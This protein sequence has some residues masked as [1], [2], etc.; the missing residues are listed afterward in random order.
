MTVLKRTLITLTSLTTLAYAGGSCD[1]SQ[2]GD[3]KVNWT[4]YKTPLKIGV[5]GSFNKVDYVAAAP[6]GKNFREI[7]V[8]S[9][10]TI[11][12]ASV[13]SNNE[14]RDATLLNAFFKKMVGEAIHAK[15]VDI[16]AQKVKRGE[17]KVG[18]VTLQVR[19]NDIAKRVPMRY[20]FKDGLL[21]ANGNIDLADFNAL[22]A[23]GTLNK[24]CFDL[25][26]GKTWSDVT[27]GF[28]MKISALLCHP[29]EIKQ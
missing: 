3:V 14:G 19:M 20:R 11:D 7:L 17:P 25:H 22:G 5:N 8:G 27:I 26:D 28:E 15:I 6:V 16:K 21:K 23:L 9:T 12:T 18:V 2:Y 13:D 29:D 4:S 10:V 1:L 24:A